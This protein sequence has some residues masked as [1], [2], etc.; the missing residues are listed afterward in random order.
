[1]S[2]VAGKVVHFAMKLYLSSMGPGGLRRSLFSAGFDT[3]LDREMQ[4]P[5]DTVACPHQGGRITMSPLSCMNSM[6]L[7]SSDR[8]KYLHTHRMQHS[9]APL[10]SQV[11]VQRHLK[12]VRITNSSLSH[13]NMG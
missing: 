1:M 13:S 4:S 5:R 3:T 7:R 2:H 11:R 12:A 9:T 8:F 6:G 10:E